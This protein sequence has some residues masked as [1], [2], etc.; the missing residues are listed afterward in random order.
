MKKITLILVLLNTY[1]SFGQCTLSLNLN[2]SNAT[3]SSSCNGS[4]VANPSGNYGP[5]TYAWNCNTCTN[6]YSSSI[7]SLCYGSA[8]TVSVTDTLG[9]SA[10]AN[11]TIV[12]APC[13]NFGANVQTTNASFTDAC[14]GSILVTPFGGTPPFNYSIQNADSLYTSNNPTNLCPGQYSINV[15]D[16]NGCNFVSA[17]NISVLDSCAGIAINFSNLINPTSASSCD[18][19]VSVS[20]SGSSGPYTYD[21]SNGL[22]SPNA[23]SLCNGVYNVCVTSS[24]GCQVCDSISI[25]ASSNV[26][27]GFFATAQ[28][29]NATDSVTCDGSMIVYAYGGTW[30]CSFSFNNST[31]TYDSTSLNLCIGT[32]VAT[33]TDANGCIYTVTGTVDTDSVNLQC[34]GFSAIAQITNAS[35][36][37]TCDGSMAVIVSNGLAPYSYIFFNTDT[38]SNSITNNLC[39]GNYSATVFDA[40]GCSVSVSGNVNAEIIVPGDTIVLNDDIVIDSSFVGSDSSDWINNCSIYYDS[41]IY[42]YISGFSTLS[43]D[44]VIVDWVL[45][46]LNGDSV[47]VSAN[48]SL[49]AGSGTY[50]LTLLLYC[51]QKSVPKYLIVNSEFDFE[52]SSL[53][54]SSF[55]SLKLYPNP[56][57]E[58]ISIDGLNIDSNY[59]I[60]DL[61]GKVLCKGKYDARID[62]STLSKGTYL[63]NISS[64][65]KKTVLRLII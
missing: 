31:P 50:L 53:L 2:V 41:I 5:V 3:D 59:E 16:N 45:N 56:A 57:N 20:V 21:W 22:S 9:C 47:I 11:W 38:T 62:I 23:D 63:V 58:F 6:V 46:Y 14:D 19:S 54:E 65:N 32:Y 64:K 44:S 17:T 25:S 12:N 40:N 1:F 30:P 34:Q 28:I 24:N 29:N 13:S 36:S 51:P 35:D 27:Q 10:T 15:I 4:V 26:C 39:V 55:E 7:D 43:N 33:V 8:G 49:N 61:N 18:A 37:V 52:T 48:Y 60:V 42:G